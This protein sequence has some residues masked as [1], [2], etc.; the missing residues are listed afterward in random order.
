[1][2]SAPE[3][4]PESQTPS[5]RGRLARS[6]LVAELRASLHSPGYQPPMLPAVALELIQLSAD[7][8]VPF[9]RVR[10]LIQS[11]PLL[12]AKVL[13]TAQSATYSRGAAITSLD[14]AMARLG[15]RTLTELFLQA[16]TSTKVFRVKGYD[17][18]MEALRKHAVVTGNVARLVCRRTGVADDYAF[19]CGLLHDV[20]MA[21][22]LL[23][24]ADRAWTGST[25]SVEDVLFGVEQVHQEASAILARVWQL[26]AD[27]QSVLEHHHNFEAAETDPKLAASICLSDW[28]ASKV[29]APAGAEVNEEDHLKAAEMLGLR[30]ADLEALV[31]AGE[32]FVGAA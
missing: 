29:G 24:L 4:S 5:A 14:D 16:A 19:M 28:I 18:P 30:P 17:R 23:I 10:A 32:N 2:T 27:V 21:A 3:I 8:N 13:H 11:E 25:P 31:L 26:P 9:H 7:P 15:L 1:M 12:A 20:G 6:V 22:S